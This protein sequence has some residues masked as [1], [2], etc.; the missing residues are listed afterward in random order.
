MGVPGTTATASEDLYFKECCCGHIYGVHQ[1]RRAPST[2]Q[3]H[4]ALE[5]FECK[6]CDCGGFAFKKEEKQQEVAE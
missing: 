3:F 2:G 1:K 5:A 4:G 6:K